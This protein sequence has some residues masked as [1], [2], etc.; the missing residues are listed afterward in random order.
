LTVSFEER[1]TAHAKLG[2]WLAPLVNGDEKNQI[3]DFDAV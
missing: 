1:K 3:V 2:G